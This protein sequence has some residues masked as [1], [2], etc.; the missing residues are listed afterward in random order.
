MRVL[1]SKIMLSYEA[2]LCV[3]VLCTMRDHALILI[4]M[5][6]I[7]PWFDMAWKGCRQKISFI[8]INAL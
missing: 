4:A 1:P 7:A 6:G 8:E 5:N 2:P 3:S